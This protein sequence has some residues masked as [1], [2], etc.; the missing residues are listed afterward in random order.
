MDLRVFDVINVVEV[1][2][3]PCRM[4]TEAHWCSFSVNW[5][6]VIRDGYSTQSLWHH[7]GRDQMTSRLASASVSPLRLFR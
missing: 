6:M 2:A 7:H 4:F 3:S 5:R 1:Q